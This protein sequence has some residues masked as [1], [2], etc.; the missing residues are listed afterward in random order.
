[1]DPAG[2]PAYAPNVIAVGGT[3]L[4]MAADGT[5]VSEVGWSCSGGGLSQL[6]SEPTWQ[7]DVQ[8]TGHRSTPDVAMI[9]DPNSGLACVSTYGDPAHPWYTTGGTSLATPCWAGLIALVNEGRAA[10]NGYSLNTSSPNEAL[11]AL[12]SVP[13][14]D[15]HGDLGGDNGASTTGLLDPT[16]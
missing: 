1:G 4:A 14:T 13:A 15:F 11:E 9:A 6:Q 2:F 12:Y 3:T 5:Y 7:Q 8:N 10:V 16:R